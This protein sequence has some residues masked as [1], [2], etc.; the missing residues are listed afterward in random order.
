MNIN[1]SS[2]EQRLPITRLR[3]RPTGRNER[4]RAERETR[5]ILKM[6]MPIEMKFNQEILVD[7]EGDYKAIY[8]TYLKRWQL[9]LFAIERMDIRLVEANTTYFS[10]MFS[11]K[12]R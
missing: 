11:P 6:L 8:D 10:D 5:T 7:T 4:R 9:A 3:K 2:P 12:E 1:E